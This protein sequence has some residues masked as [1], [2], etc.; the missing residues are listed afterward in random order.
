MNK[1]LLSLAI[2]VAM[3]FKTS[4]Q[5]TNTATIDATSG[6]INI[7]SKY[8][9][10][11]FSEHLGNCI[12]DGIWVGKDS[13]I[14]NQAGIRTDV[15]EALKKLHV[16]ALRW[17]GGCFADEYHW[18][19]GIGLTKDRPKMIN[20]NWGVV[21]EDNSFGTDEF[22]DLC[23]KLD[24][25]AYIS[26]NL[27]SGTVQEMSQWVEYLNSDNESPM[28]NLRKQNGRE[29]S[30]G[31]KFWGVGNESWGCGGK[32]KAQYYADKALQ[33]SAFLKNYG[34]NNLKQIAVGPNA[35]DYNWTDVLMRETGTHFWGI[36]LHYYTTL[37]GSAT[38]FK[39]SEWFKVMQSTLKMEEIIEKHAA[40]M[41]TYDPYKKVGLV[42]DE[43]GTWFD[44]E[45][46][47][48]PGFLYQQNSLRDAL[49]AGVNLNIFNNHSDRVKMTCIAQVVNVLQ[50]MILTKGENMVLTPTYY[51]FDMFKVHQDAYLVP[52]ELSC[53]N[54]MYEGASV[55]A[56][57][58][59]S[60][61]DN[62]GKMHISICNLHATKNE[63][64]VCNLKGFDPLGI[65]GKIITANKLNA[66]N[67]FDD[68]IQISDK[69]FSDFSFKK[70]QLT[71]NIPPHS[72]ITLE[73]DG[74]LNVDNES[75][76]LKKPVKGIK[77]K[78]YDGDWEVIPDYKNLQPI[79]TGLVNNIVFPE[80]I[81]GSNFLL[82]YDGFIK[83]E[84]DGLYNFSLA[85]DDGAKLFINN[86]MVINNDGRHGTVEHEG[87]K[88]LGKGFY[89]F[90]LEYFQAG[91]G[92]V[93]ELNKLVKVNNS[94]EPVKFKDEDFWHEK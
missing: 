22:M 67:S 92:K 37:N 41:D 51:V 30:Y 7:I 32:M 56:L 89:P 74:D 4:A 13:K 80:D 44:V 29:K 8:I 49:V 38:N 63:K 10:S 79:K 46:N 60:S 77:Y 73:V 16:P 24:C 61:I 21:T 59:S 27:G 1:T 58:M 57:N 6:N 14:P 50:S 19:D 17:P 69:L 83:I 78:L 25:E 12:Y 53:E 18:K 75:V 5:T 48:N 91:G 47:T 3:A 36:S 64:L 87:I 70:N 76:K 42:V 31:V 71:I 33:F 28:T 15:V 94:Y 54:Y 65:T 72:V 35:T 23:Q 26:G 11:Q 88:Y 34:S 81:P 45:P 20:T 62:D 93:L 55:P 82:I 68:P 85:S 52:S 43:W 86:N 84:K 39:E 40:I 2:V 9:Y 90:R 66:Y